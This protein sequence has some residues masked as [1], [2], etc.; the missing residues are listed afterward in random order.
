MGLKRFR[1][2]T[3][4]RRSMTSLTFE[5]ITKT[6]PEKSLTVKLKNKAGHN[7]YGRITSRFRGGGHKRKYRVIDFRRTKDGIPGR[8]AAIEYDPNRTSNI[9]LVHYVDGEKAYII[10][11]KGLEVG[12]TV[13]NGPESE[14]SVGNHLPLRNIPIG[15][16]IHCIEIKIGKGAQIVRSAGTSAQL[17]AKDAEFAH[18]RLPSGEVRLIHTRC[19]ATLGEVG[20]S[21]HMHVVIG[22][23]GRSRWMGRR[24]HNRGSVMNPCDHPHGGGEGKAGQGRTPVSPWGWPTKGLKT[25]KN[26]KKSSKYIVESRKKRN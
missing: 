10:A 8:V 25:R 15:S 16:T 24:P 18:V 21:D 2:V 3:P 23:A 14:I 26:K 11:P 13:M 7:N 9:A 19:R 4:T 5:E 12:M 17:I 1:P 6:T 22:K 20:N